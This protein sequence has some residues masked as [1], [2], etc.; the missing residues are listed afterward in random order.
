[1]KQYLKNALKKERKMFIYEVFEKELISID[2]KR[3][4]I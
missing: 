2:K 4:L 1:M 3:I